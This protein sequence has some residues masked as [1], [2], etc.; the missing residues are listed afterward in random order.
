MNG[1]LSNQNRRS[2]G[3]TLLLSSLIGLF[4]ITAL[5]VIV[6]LF[7]TKDQFDRAKEMLPILV[8]LITAVLAA[9]M[10][11]YFPKKE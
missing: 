7:G 3:R 8:G 11:F 1:T 4:L 5:L 6:A 10:A 2:P 9:A